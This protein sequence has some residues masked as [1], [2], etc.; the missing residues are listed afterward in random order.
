MSDHVT[1]F[2]VVSG[3][4]AGLVLSWLAQRSGNT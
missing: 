1:A 3:T 4:L 2:Y